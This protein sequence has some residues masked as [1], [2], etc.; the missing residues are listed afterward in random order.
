[1]LHNFPINCAVLLVNSQERQ[2]PVGH[3]Y[4]LIAVANPAGQ[5]LPKSV[6]ALPVFRLLGLLRL[7]T[8]GDDLGRDSLTDG[9]TFS[10]W[11]VNLVFINSQEPFFFLQPSFECFFHGFVRDL[12]LQKPSFGSSLEEI[13]Q[14][15]LKDG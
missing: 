13:R 12:A 2:A 7:F 14:W 11:L 1:M 8:S 10:Y 15:K 6:I 5:K 4:R 9:H 3:A